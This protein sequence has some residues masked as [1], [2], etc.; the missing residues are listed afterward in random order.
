[1][2][3]RGLIAAPALLLA[4][5]SCGSV[6]TLPSA[7][8]Q[9]T[10]EE[11]SVDNTGNRASTNSPAIFVL[12]GAKAPGIYEYA[13]T[14]AGNAAPIRRVN[15][16]GGFGVDRVGQI[17]SLDP[18]AIDR[19]ECAPCIGSV[20]N[21]AGQVLHKFR[22]P[23]SP[24]RSPND[25]PFRPVT[26][27][28]GNVYFIRQFS[29]EID[30]VSVRTGGTAK[31]VRIIKLPKEA[32]PGNR[33]F[34]FNP[35]LCVSSIGE[36]YYYGVYRKSTPAE[37]IWSSTASGSDAPLRVLIGNGVQEGISGVDKSGNAYARPMGSL[38]LAYFGPK[39]NGNARPTLA[40]LQGPIGYAT[41]LTVSRSSQ[42]LYEGR[43]TSSGH[44][45]LLTSPTPPSAPQRTLNLPPT[46][47][48]FETIFTTF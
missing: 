24:I 40:T 7:S 5:A 46:F 9:S 42:L 33:Q 17:Y 31:V 30:E 18:V 10:A 16:D 32:K 6:A 28:D 14:A 35:R 38:Q 1:V 15:W 29:F 45:A 48:G 43:L 37:Y 3:L 25:M 36:I 44:E 22:F 4:F 11:A 8:L 34:E 23:T 39:A 19:M 12:S 13:R 20:R 27:R 21:A 41:Q 26:D 2:L 47:D